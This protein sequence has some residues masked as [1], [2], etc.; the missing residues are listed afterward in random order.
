MNK[1]PVNSE[2]EITLKMIGGKC[3]PLILYILIEEGPKRF[4]D[5]MGQVNQISQKTLTNQLR[6]LE[7]DGLI[8]REA[9]SEIPPRVEYSI[10]EKGKT[11]FPILD[12]MCEWGEKNNN[13]R[14]E[15]INPQCIQC[16]N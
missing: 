11:L 7:S 12:L 8:L 6:E 13:G 16:N 1:I 5:L 4:K 9:F 2:I 3:K 15:I 10:T 14:F